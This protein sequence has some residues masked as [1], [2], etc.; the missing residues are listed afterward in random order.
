MA[1][2]HQWV[3]T[4]CSPIKQ[5]FV[6]C[7]I[8]C[9]SVNLFN[10]MSFEYLQVLQSYHSHPVS[11]SSTT[12][13]LCFWVFMMVVCSIMSLTISRGLHKTAGI[14]L[15]TALFTGWMTFKSSRL[16]F[17]IWGASES[18]CT[19]KVFLRKRKKEKMLPHSP[20]ASQ[21]S[22]TLCWSLM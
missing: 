13:L 6:D 11:H 22:T 18:K 4:C 16:L 20:S 1:F 14:K 10:H 19:P 2:L 15:H 7:T 5:S 17:L 12:D 9:C 3:S 8:S 21:L